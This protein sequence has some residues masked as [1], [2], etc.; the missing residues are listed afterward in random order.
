MKPNDGAPYQR[1]DREI[2][3]Q[4]YL[5]REETRIQERMPGEDGGRDWSEA[6]Q[7]KK[8]SGLPGAARHWKNL[9]RILP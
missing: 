4:R 1:K 9:G 2:W 5:G 8:H 3:A 6:E 7:T